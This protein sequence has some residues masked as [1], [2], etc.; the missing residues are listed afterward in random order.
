M[1]KITPVA[2]HQQHEGCVSTYAACSEASLLYTLGEMKFGGYIESR[3][4]TEV[5]QKAALSTGSGLR[6]PRR[7]LGTLGQ[8][9]PETSSLFEA[10]VPK[11]GGL[12]T[13]C[14]QEFPE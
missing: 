6:V 10:R 1:P 8:R 7:L 12:E 4:T 11:Q 5:R 2:L 9:L 13:F 14:T 3:A